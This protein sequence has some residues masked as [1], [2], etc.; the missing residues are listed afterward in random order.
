MVRRPCPETTPAASE[1]I[2]RKACRTN[3]V[4]MKMAAMLNH[5]GTVWSSRRDRQFVEWLAPY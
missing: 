2:T 4:T 5:R 3:A 1:T